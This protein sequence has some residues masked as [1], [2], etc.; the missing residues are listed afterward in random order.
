[1]E[2]AWIKALESQ[3]QSGMA[4]TL[5]RCRRHPGAGRDPER[6]MVAVRLDSCQHR[7]IDKPEIRF[8]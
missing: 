7:N 8:K 4:N 2:E 3:G 1:M 6:S 5:A